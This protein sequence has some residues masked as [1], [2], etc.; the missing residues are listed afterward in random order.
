MKI[1]EIIKKYAEAKVI[2]SNW[3]KEGSIIVRP[4]IAATRA[5]ICIK[6]PLNIPKGIVSRLVAKYIRWRIGLKHGISL[7]IP[8]SKELGRCSACYC[9]SDLKIWLPLETIK[10]QMSER[11]KYDD[12]CWL[13]KM[14]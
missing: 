8:N 10:P 14:H 1:I 6:C 12:D 5:T 3:A 7:N 13:F 11:V 9:E 2:I 4:Q